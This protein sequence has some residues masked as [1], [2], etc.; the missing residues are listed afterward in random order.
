[1]EENLNQVN[2][3]LNDLSP[4]QKQKILDD[5][6]NFKMYLGK[7]VSRGEKLGLSE[8]AL[9]KGAKLVGDH[10]AKH[11]DPQNSEEKLLQELWKVTESEDEK[12]TLSKLLVR[13]VK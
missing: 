4:E 6:E 3:K 9:A 2:K 8:D 12:A 7:Q 1:M 11:E 5:F 10:L 13:L